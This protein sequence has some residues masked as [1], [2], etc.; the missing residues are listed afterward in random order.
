MSRINELE[1]DKKRLKAAIERIEAK[2]RDIDDCA[3]VGSDPAQVAS[4]IESKGKAEILLGQKETEIKIERENNR[5]R[6]I[7]GIKTRAIDI[8]KLSL[9]GSLR[10][11]SLDKNSAN[12]II[13][14]DMVDKIFKAERDE[15]VRREKLLEEGFIVQRS[16]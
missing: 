5:L 16:M 1:T 10:S 3:D 4:L 9:G 2:L 8:A 13:K 12:E 7:R 6:D 14:R 15:V 11:S